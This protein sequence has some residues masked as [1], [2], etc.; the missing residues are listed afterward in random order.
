LVIRNFKKILIIFLLI[1][2]LSSSF[3]GCGRIDTGPS[4]GGGLVPNYYIEVFNPP[5]IYKVKEDK[6]FTINIHP[7]L[8]GVTGIYRMWFN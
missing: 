7:K 1:A 5:D 2:F 4:D 3:Y 6:L 8:N